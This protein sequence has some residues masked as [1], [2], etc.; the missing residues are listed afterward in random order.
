MM[1]FSPASIQSIKSISQHALTLYWSRLARGRSFPSF[2]EFDPGPRLHDPKQLVI[3]TIEDAF[4]QRRFRALY[5]GTNVAEVFNS[6]W[7]GRTM[8][9]VVPVPLKSMSVDGANECAASG[10]AI[11]TIFATFD[12]NGHRVD[13][14][15]LLL[16][17]GEGSTVQ[18][19]VASLQLISIKGEFERKS[20]L[21]KF[22]TLSQA[23]F[24]GRIR[25]GS[26]SVATTD[27]S[28]DVIMSQ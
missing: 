13:C 6:S 27:D 22:E 3:W 1:Q 11:Y 7:G 2:A 15:R 10:C 14:E 21:S 23:V 8:D 26:I 12:A 18:Q 5:Q 4:G 19:I 9:E 28:A 24:M 20:V 17:L 16:P 25:S